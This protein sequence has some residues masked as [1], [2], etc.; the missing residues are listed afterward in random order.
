MIAKPIDKIK[1]AVDDLM[2]LAARYDRGQCIQ[3]DE[4][5]KIAG[6]RFDNRARH[7]IGKWR[8]R[9]M[10]DREIVTLCSLGVGVRLLTHEETLKEVPA[11][12]QRKAY[13]QVRKALRE[14]ETID[15]GRLSDHQRRL[16]ASQK[17]NMADQRRQLFRSRKELRGTE[18][19]DSMPLRKN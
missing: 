10:K 7:I 19:G 2:S 15:V 12:R 8:R 1:E 9:L 14:V 5:E 11:I 13:R 4:I 16:L 17:S 6:S 3:W 18:P